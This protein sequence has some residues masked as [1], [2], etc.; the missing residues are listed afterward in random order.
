MSG[1]NIALYSGNANPQLSQLVAQKLGTKIC[2][3]KVGRFS[4]NE[5]NVELGQSVRGNDVFIIQPSAPPNPSENLMEILVMID[6][7]KR[8]SAKRITAVLPYFGFGRQDRRP[9]SSRVP[10]TARLVANMLTTAG[11]DRIL[12][13]D[14]HADQI[15]GFFNIPVDNVYASPIFTN[16][17]S[18][19]IQNPTV[20]SPDVGGVVRARALAKQL[21]A[22]LAIVD[23]RR[24]KDNVSE[25]MNI[26][27]DVTNRNCVIFDDIVDTAG[28]LCKAAGALKQNGA[29][30][31]Y[32]C[33]THGVLSG[34]AVTNIENSQLDGVLVSNTIDVQE[35]AQK[36]T[37]IDIICIAKMLSDS[38]SRIHRENSIRSMYPSSMG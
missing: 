5:I 20:V 30:S 12:T 22:D 29:K 15:Q 36:S 38:I 6:A 13:I 24:P 16:K 25:V 1:Y 21:N 17:I 4:D 23:K 27:G 35:K 32:A 19:K 26:I 34:D 14:L 8:S 31:V 33:C 37:K 18:K 7:V 2:K 28:T 10:I 3:A 9:W 11:A